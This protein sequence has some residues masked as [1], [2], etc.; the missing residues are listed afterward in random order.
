MSNLHSKELKDQI[1]VQ[2]GLTYCLKEQF[3]LDIEETVKQ[4]QTVVDEVSA[5]LGTTLRIVNPHQ[6]F[7]RK[8]KSANSQGQVVMYYNLLMQNTQR[9]DTSLEHG[10][11]EL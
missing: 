6:N 1:A 3:T 11:Q 8:V 5:M 10:I 4:L 7:T 9:T 2:Q